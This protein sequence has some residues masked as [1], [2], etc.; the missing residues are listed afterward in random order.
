MDDKPVD[1]THLVFVVHGIG[2]KMDNSAIVKS[3]QEYVLL[4]VLLKFSTVAVT[5]KYFFDYNKS[6]KL[7]SAEMNRETT[8]SF[9][10]SLLLIGL[11]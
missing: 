1:I 5:Y 7:Y 6:W 10:C 11:F 8:L 4:L 9:F 2:Q 3:C